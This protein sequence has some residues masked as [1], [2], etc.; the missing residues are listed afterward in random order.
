M[1]RLPT[2]VPGTASLQFTIG[3]SVIFVSQN[4]TK[5]T[6]KWAEASGR[7]TA[8]CNDGGLVETMGRGIGQVV[9]RGGQCGEIGAVA[10]GRRRR[11]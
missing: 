6:Y 8:L 9:V 7:A 4:P 5:I 10:S 1:P 11:K 3:K 2:N